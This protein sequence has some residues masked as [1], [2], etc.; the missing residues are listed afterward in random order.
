MPAHGVTLGTLS[1]ASVVLSTAVTEEIAGVGF[2]QAS[3]SA[4]VGGQV[5]QPEEGVLVAPVLSFGDVGQSTGG[6]SLSPSMSPIPHRIVIKAQSGQFVDMSNF[7]SD[8]MASLQQL[9][10][11]GIQSTVSA[12]PG[13][14]RPRLR[15]VSTLPPW[16]FCFLA[17][18]M[19][20]CTG[21]AHTRFVLVM[22]T[23][24]ACLH[25]PA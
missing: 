1:H 24:G 19:A 3:P 17:Y 25:M 12:F 2:A 15:D 10:A 16:L 22:L 4:T 23:Q 21:D 14:P 11:F 9:E 18:N 13:T 7:L 8:N 5:L 20:V 6:L